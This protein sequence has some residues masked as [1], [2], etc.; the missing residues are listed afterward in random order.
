MCLL[1]NLS[2][3]DNGYIEVAGNLF[4]L[5]FNHAYVVHN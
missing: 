3:M 1:I 2:C 5:H 4:G